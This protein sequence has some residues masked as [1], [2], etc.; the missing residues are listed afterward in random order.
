MGHSYTCHW[1]FSFTFEPHHS[2]SSTDRPMITTGGDAVLDILNLGE[3]HITV[4]FSSHILFMIVVSILIHE[5][6]YKI[7][8]KT[9]SG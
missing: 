9:Q 5:N 8:N 7:S 4:S 2:C 1:G 6:L 3:I